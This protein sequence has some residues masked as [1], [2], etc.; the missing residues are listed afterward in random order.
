VATFYLIRHAEKDADN[1]LMVG[2]TE[3][4]GLTSRGREQAI[5]IAERL[6]KRNIKHLLCS[7]LD[8]AQQTAEPLARSLGLTVQTSSALHELDFGLWTG[9]TLDQLATMPGW[10]EFNMFRSGSRPPEGE[11][12]VAV[13]ARM[14][15]E[16]LRLGAAFPED[17]IALV[18]HGDPIR[19]ALIYFLGAPVDMFHRLHVSIGSI[20]VLELS[21]MN[22]VVQSLNDVPE[23]SSTR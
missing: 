17:E 10:R 13:Q 23:V 18:S 4:I 12:M 6:R 9:K 19:A 20:S 3:G 14:V 5:A 22:S 1:Q 8:R 21:A 7:P 11:T 2:R 15:H 16:I